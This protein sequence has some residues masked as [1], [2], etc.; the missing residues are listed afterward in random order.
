MN[1]HGWV[2]KGMI[3]CERERKAWLGM[4]WLGIA[5]NMEGSIKFIYKIGL[6]FD[7]K[8]NR[9]VWEAME[10]YIRTLLYLRSRYIAPLLLGY[11]F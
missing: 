2:W 6:G 3:G 5:S 8:R 1:G 7:L 9:T 4:A 11:K 10:G